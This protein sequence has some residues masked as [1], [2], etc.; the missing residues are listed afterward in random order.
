MK[1]KNF[2]QYKTFKQA[3]K[4]ADNPKDK[5]MLLDYVTSKKVKSGFENE[6]FW[7]EKIWKQIRISN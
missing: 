1:L 4:V 7:I 2:L 6:D 3:F 5:Q